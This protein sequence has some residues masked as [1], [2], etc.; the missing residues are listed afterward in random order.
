MPVRAGGAESANSSAPQPIRSS[1]A[2]FA[3]LE[4]A[5]D[6]LAADEARLA[7][8]AESPRFKGM[9]GDAIGR[10]VV[11]GRER[12]EAAAREETRS[13]IAQQRQER[14]RE[15]AQ[16]ER[17]KKALLREVDKVRAEV[18]DAE[19]L[20]AETR[21]KAE[22]DES[23][24][25]TAADYLVESRDRIIRDFSAFHELIEKARASV[26]SSANGHHPPVA[27]VLE[28][29]RQREPWSRPMAR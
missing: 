10:E 13:F 1:A 26:N 7:D 8:L 20:R 3:R 25:R 21:A 9:L 4:A 24:I 11:T 16:A 19:N 22:R 27:K 6:A 5:L 18:A 29:L 23:S 15:K 28:V 14:E 2:R 17:E 12:I